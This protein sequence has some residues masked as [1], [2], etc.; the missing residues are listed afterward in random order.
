VIDT[1]RHFVAAIA[2]M[3]TCSGRAQRSDAPRQFNTLGGAKFG[4]TPIGTVFAF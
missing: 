3:A 4:T 1:E 2:K